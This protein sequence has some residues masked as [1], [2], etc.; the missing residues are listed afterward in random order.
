MNDFV[1]DIIDPCADMECD[2]LCIKDDSDTAVCG[3]HLGYELDQDGKTCN[4]IDECADP[5]LNLC[6]V[7][8]TCSNLDGGYTCIC[9]DD[10]MLAVDGRTCIGEP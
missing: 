6:D 8:A 5:T 7:N 10:L 1:V 9:P 2:H 3:C 4:D